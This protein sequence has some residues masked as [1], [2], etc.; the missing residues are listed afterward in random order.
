MPDALMTTL[1]AVAT[2]PAQALPTLTAEQ[3]ARIALRG[4]HRTV[5]EGEVLFEPGDRAV[6]TFVVVSGELQ[7]V[8]PSNGTHT[9]VVTYRPGHF[10]GEVNA[11]NGRPAIARLR[12]TEPGEVIQLDR[13]QLLALIQ[14]DAELSELFMRALILRRVA[15][16]ARQLSDAV[17]VGSAHN[18]GTLRVKEFLLRNDHPFQ[19]LD[20]DRDAQAREVLDRFQIEVADIPV[21]ICRDRA[22]LR[23]PTNAQVAECLGFNEEI[24]QTHLHD[25]VVVGAGPAGLAAAVYAASEGLDVVVLESSLP[26]G[27]AG[28]SSRIENYLGFPTGISGV[29]LTNRAYAQ[30]LKFGAHFAMTRGASRLL[31]EGERYAI[32]MTSGVRIQT[33]TVVIATGAEYRRPAL[34]NLATFEGAGVYYCAT[35]ME[36]QRCA[37]VD[38][39][40]VGGGNSAG[41]A[42]VFLAATARQVTILVRGDALADTMS[43]YLIRR[44]SE[45]PAIVVRTQT[46]IVGLDGDRSLERVRCLD[47]RTGDVEAHEIG[48]VFIMAGAVPN[49]GWLGECV[50]LD[51]NGFVKVGTSLS[52][53]ELTSWNWPLARAP[54]LLETSR[55]GIF[56]VGDVRGGSVKRVAS[57]VGE[58]SIAVSFVHQAL[59]AAS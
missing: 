23:N 45:H 54:Y 33:R 1:A 5:T 35:P 7:V 53:D 25:L 52:T 42:A 40:V 58:G 22:V 11:I 47:R 39:I 9:V 46:Q 50:A 28:A 48:H 13:E 24:D 18:A 12:V 32:E 31:C 21:V 56:A 20:V 8:I 10:S 43:Q 15:L 3:M 27:Q 57:A 37:G 41:Q 44:V 36:A 6:P 16:I 14:A 17:V 29:D 34:P 19:Y 49:T 26:G 2:L 30:A 55:P 59:S 51:D 38:V 4:R